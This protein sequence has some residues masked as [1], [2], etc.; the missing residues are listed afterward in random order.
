[1]D[2]NRKLISEL[3]DFFK[4]GDAGSAIDH[5]SSVMGSL[6]IQNRVMGVSKRP[7]C[8]FT[9]VQVLQLMLIMSFFQVKNA[10]G[11]A[12]S[13][14]HKLFVCQKDM[15]Y[16]FLNNELVDWRGINYSVFRQLY[17]RIC[18]NTTKKREA[19]CLIIDDTDLPKTGF[20]MEGIGKVFSHTEMKRILGFK[21][22]FLCFT[23]GVSQFLL[24]SSLHGE[25]GRDK[26]K[27]QGLKKEQQ[28]ARYSRRRA[29]G[30]RAAQRG[31]EYFTDKQQCAISMLKRAITEGLRFEYLLVDRWFTCCGLLKFIKSR[32]FNCNLL[33]MVKM[34]NWKYVTKKGKKTAR[35]IVD[36]LVKSKSVRHCRSIGYRTATIDVKVDGIAVK[37]LFFNKGNGDNWNALLSSDLSL[38]PE[39]AFKLYSRRWTIEVAHRDMKQNLRLGKCQSRDFAAQIASV[40]ICMLQYNILSCVKR[41][42]SYETLGGLFAEA[43][44]GTAEL[45]V[46]EE[47]WL[48]IQEVVGVIAEALGCD[49]MSLIEIAMRDS[50]KLRRLKRACSRLVSLAID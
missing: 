21:A 17:S 14:L 49:D 18:Q 34:G 50:A 15:F 16:R 43:T 29:P 31:M 32:H 42:S 9:H 7:N 25:T 46:A 41:F 33:G 5:I 37:L 1:M 35:E 40:T 22:M 26:E 24:D 45:S 39:R 3:Q 12:S 8:K 10:Y 19:R 23:D 38:T 27:P 4:N 11:Y 20:R 2:K 48:M 28:R 13:A 47:I 6:R 30:S 36:G 44:K